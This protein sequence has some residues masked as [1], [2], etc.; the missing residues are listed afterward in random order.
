[1]RPLEPAQRAEA[2]QGSREGCGR[3]GREEADKKQNQLTSIPR[4]SRSQYVNEGLLRRQASP[5]SSH[6]RTVAPGAGRVRLS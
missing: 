2:E 3:K 5:A 1:M 6:L 4:Q